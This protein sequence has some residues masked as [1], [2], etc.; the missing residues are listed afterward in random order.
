[1]SFFVQTKEVMTY[2]RPCLDKRSHD[3]LQILSGQQKFWTTQSLVQTTEFVT[4]LG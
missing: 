3:L 1:M 4:C 2:P